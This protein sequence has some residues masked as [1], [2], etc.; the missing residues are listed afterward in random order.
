MKASD[1]CLA[2]IRHFEAFMTRPYLCPAGVPTIGYGSTHYEDGT[3]V[4]LADPA[5]TIQRA[6]ALMRN[7]LTRYED[8]VSHYVTGTINQNQF[9]ALVD[10]A[11]NVGT[12]N[13]KTSTLLKRVNSG[14]IFTAA[15]EFGKWNHC[16]GKV[17][18][19]LTERREAE[20]ILFMRGVTI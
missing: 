16:D 1:N 4:T 12:Q 8:M 14:S 17:L 19:G 2:I 15:N 10:F 18:R 20:R 9:D 13:L 3:A 6:E 7:T 5:I 11:Y